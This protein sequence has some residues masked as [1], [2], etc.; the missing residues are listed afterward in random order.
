[1]D[2]Q[3]AVDGGTPNPKKLSVDSMRIADVTPNVAA[4]TAAIITRVTKTI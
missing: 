4:K 1:M 2:P 3:L